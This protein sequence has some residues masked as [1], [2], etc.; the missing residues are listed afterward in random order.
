MD[1]NSGELKKQVL[2]NFW[3][4]YDTEGTVQALNWLESLKYYEEYCLV[5]DDGI[6]S[7]TEKLQKM[8]T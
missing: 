3:S 6:A 7:L 2:D 1:M 5:M 8:S 4:I